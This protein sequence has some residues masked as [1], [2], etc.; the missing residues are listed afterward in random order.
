M[1]QTLIWVMLLDNKAKKGG[2]RHMT[3]CLFLHKN[4]IELE[5]HKNFQGK[6]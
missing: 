2:S 3:K 5:G 6:K 4:I 1:N